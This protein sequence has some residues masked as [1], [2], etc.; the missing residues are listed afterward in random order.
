[1][2]EHE[3]V[4]SRRSE[5]GGKDNMSIVAEGRYDMQEFQQG[6]LAAYGHDHLLQTRKRHHKVYA[7][8][9]IT[10][11]EGKHDPSF[12]FRGEIAII[13]VVKN[14][15]WKGRGMSEHFCHGCAR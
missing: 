13:V 15:E 5:C 1:M 9:A 4:E 3:V 10:V 7:L 2:F 12:S 11:L 6:K 8:H 14:D